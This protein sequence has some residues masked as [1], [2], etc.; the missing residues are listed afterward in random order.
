MLS[1]KMKR[2]FVLIKQIHCRLHRK[3]EVLKLERAILIMSDSARPIVLPS[4]GHELGCR[5]NP[6]SGQY[7][8]RRSASVA[9]ALKMKSRFL[10]DQ[11]AP[12]LQEWGPGSFVLT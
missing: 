1:L 12:S 5:H 3:V 11:T 6:N 4:C 7:L 9:A 8:A 10:A 2:H